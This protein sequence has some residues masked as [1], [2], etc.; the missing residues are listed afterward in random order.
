MAVLGKFKPGKSSFL[1]SLAGG[2]ILPVGVIPSTAVVTELYRAP[3]PTAS[4]RLLE[5]GT[6]PVPVDAIA[7]YVAE[8]KN[9]GNVRGAAAVDAALARM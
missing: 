6:R 7:D 2:E 9:P 3:E 5:G 4:V 8:E 1:N